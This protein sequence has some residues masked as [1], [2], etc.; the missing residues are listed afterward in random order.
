M[1]TDSPSAA[2]RQAAINAVA[3]LRIL[4]DEIGE[5]HWDG[6]AHRAADRLLG[7]VQDFD[8]TNICMHDGIEDASDCPHAIK[9]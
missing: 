3:D 2:L 9:L 5:P 7:A 4:A 8:R 1:N 6:P